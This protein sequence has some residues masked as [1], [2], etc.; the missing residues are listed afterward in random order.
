MG[1]EVRRDGE[2][3]RRSAER[4]PGVGSEHGQYLI[5]TRAH[6]LRL[7]AHELYDSIG[8]FQEIVGVSHA[9]HLLVCDHHTSI[10]CDIRT[11]P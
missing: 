8:H 11:I 7:M 2:E 1:G 4:T 9:C 5:T 3:A 10:D 6:T